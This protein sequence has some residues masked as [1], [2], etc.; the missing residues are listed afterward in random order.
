MLFV[1]ILRNIQTRLYS[2]KE[3]KM[4]CFHEKVVSKY[5]NREVQQ[6]KNQ[7]VHYK[8][9]LVYKREVQNCF[10]PNSKFEIVYQALRQA[11]AS[12]NSEG[13]LYSASVENMLVGKQF[14]R[15]FGIDNEEEEQLK[16]VELSDYH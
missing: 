8:N 14:A 9:K 3:N 6:E 4:I 11:I 2:E 7:L 1:T 5:N 12:R 13:S 16:Q 15:N 10:F